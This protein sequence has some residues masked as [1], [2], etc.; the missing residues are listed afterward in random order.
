MLIIRVLSVGGLNS[1]YSENLG[2][3]N[4]SIMMERIVKI[5]KKS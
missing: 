5:S 4:F 1:E 2:K 3:E